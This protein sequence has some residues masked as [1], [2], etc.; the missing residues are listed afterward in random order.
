MAIPVIRSR[1][2][3]VGRPPMEHRQG[4]TVAGGTDHRHDVD[5][6]AA[7]IDQRCDELVLG[8]AQPTITPDLVVNPA[9]L[10]RART[11]RLLA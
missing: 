5:A 11:A 1:S 9:A 4:S 10:A 7:E 3:F 2:K 6:D 8:L